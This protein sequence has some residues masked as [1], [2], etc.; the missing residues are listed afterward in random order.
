MTSKVTLS[1]LQ[2]PKIFQTGKVL[3]IGT[4]GGCDIITAYVVAQKL[5][6]L[7]KAVAWGNTKRPGRGNP[8]GSPDGCTPLRPGSHLHIVNESKPLVQDANYYGTC[9]IDGSIP[10][11]GVF[12]SPI[13]VRLPR[14]EKEG[15]KVDESILKDIA[16]EI[17]THLPFDAILGVDAGGDALTGGIDHDGDPS[18][19]V[20]QMMGRVLS[21]TGLPFIL[22]VCGLGCDGESSMALIRQHMNREIKEGAYLGSVPMHS[23]SGEFKTLAHALAPTRTPNLMAAACDRD[24]HPPET[25]SELMVI[26]RGPVHQSIP[27]EWLSRAYFFSRSDDNRPGEAPESSPV[28]TTLPDS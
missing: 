6:G 9:G 15:D 22:C 3:V 1:E 24:T 7:S 19:G 23:W 20:D 16:A 21:Y 17:R 5:P 8:M 27:V 10:K 4:G 11:E 28:W 13:I 25:S 12:G 26:R 2:L 14:P 18:T